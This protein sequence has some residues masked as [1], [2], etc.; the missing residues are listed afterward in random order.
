MDDDLAFGASVWAASEPAAVRPIITPPPVT[1][2]VSFD[3]FDDFGPPT[4]AETTHDDGGDDDFGDFGDFGEAEDLATPADF[5]EEGVVFE[6]MRIAGPSSQ[7]ADWEPLRLDPMPSRGE[8]EAQ[9]NDILAPVWDQDISQFTT[10][11]EIREVEGVSQILATPERC[12][13]LPI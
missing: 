4:D 11:E 10:D 5:G 3:D 12:R 8:L 6:E 1:Q 9:V 7:Y 13:G 2:A